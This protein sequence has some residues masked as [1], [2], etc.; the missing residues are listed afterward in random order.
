MR[1]P[2]G[3]QVN[4]NVYALQRGAEINC[5]REILSDKPAERP[6]GKIKP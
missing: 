5:F 2:E 3:M 6:G 4:F 1:T